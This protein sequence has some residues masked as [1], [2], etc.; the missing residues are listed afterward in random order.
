MLAEG[1]LRLDGQPEASLGITPVEEELPLDR[2]VE[3]KLKDGDAVLYRGR[4]SSPRN[5]GIRR[6]YLLKRSGEEWILS[7]L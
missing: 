5:V 2:P 6:S 7:P 4:L 1:F 3:I